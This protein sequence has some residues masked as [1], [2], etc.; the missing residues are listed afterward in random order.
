MYYLIVNIEKKDIFVKIIHCKRSAPLQK[1]NS[2]S[3][4]EWEIVCQ[5]EGEA[6]THVGNTSIILKKG[7]I[8][9]IPP[10]MAHRGVSDGIFLDASVRVEDPDFSKLTVLHDNRGDIIYLILMIDRIMTE[11]QGDYKSVAESLAES[12]VK[13]IKYEI[14]IAS[15]SPE[16]EQV[17]KDIYE[18]ISNPDFSLAQSI[19]QTGFDKDYFRRCFKKAT[20]KTPTQYLT[21]M[22]IVS[23]KQLLK[24][25]KMFSVASIAESCG[26]SDSLY[27][28][29]CFK[30]HVGL[31]PL[32]YRKKYMK[33]PSK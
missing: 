32:V 15:D 29:T 19:A 2:H 23:A 5:V 11:S 12:M 9:L 14:G 25:K 26:F 20:G 1:Y 16:I 3:H 17:K 10:N 30:K 24:D 8:L 7:D 31:S 28:S 4:K 27:F 13:I 33:D 21:D 18:N 6:L 22:R